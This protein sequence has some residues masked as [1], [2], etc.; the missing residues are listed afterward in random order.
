MK[1]VGIMQIISA[2]HF[3]GCPAGENGC[4]TSP[5]YQLLIH[6]VCYGVCFLKSLQIRCISSFA[7]HHGPAVG[8]V[9]WVMQGPPLSVPEVLDQLEGC[10]CTQVVGAP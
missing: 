8:Q 6:S 1:L 5:R 10:V 4:Q 9:A 7:L 3:E 2:A